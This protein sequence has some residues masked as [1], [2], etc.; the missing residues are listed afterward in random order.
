M[1]SFANNK[2]ELKDQI[3]SFWQSEGL[4]WQKL[5]FKN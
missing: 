3:D 4:N 5:N 2:V 1:A